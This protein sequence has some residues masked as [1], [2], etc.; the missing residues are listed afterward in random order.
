MNFKET[1]QKI[2]ENWAD[3]LP[4]LTPG[5][6]RTNVNGRP[7]YICPFCNHGAHGDGLAVKPGTTNIR[8]FACGFSGSII[9]LYMKQEDIGFKEAVLALAD[10]LGL[11]IENGMNANKHNQPFVSH[12]SVFRKGHPQELST[13]HKESQTT[14]DTASQIDLKAYY[15]VCSS[16]L[17]ND[18]EA[19][20]YLQGRG[21]SLDN[22]L[23]HGFGYDPEADP[24]GRGY[25]TKRII[26]PTS[27]THYV[28]RAIDPSLDRRSKMNNKGGKPGLFNSDVL[29][30]S[31]DA[32]F[33]VEGII[34][35]VSIMEC[36]DTSAIALNGTGNINL[37]IE[38]VKKQAPVA[39]LVIC[40]DN[41]E[42]GKK[43]TEQLRSELQ[44]FNI[45]FKVANIFGKQK[46]ANEALLKNRKRFFEEIQRAKM[47][48]AARPDNV[49]DHSITFM[50]D[51]I[52]KYKKQINT[53]YKGLDKI[54]GGLFAGL[55]VVA[56]ITSI[57][58]TAFVHQMAD[59]IAAS[60]QDI[61]FFSLEHSRLELVSKSIARQIAKDNYAEDKCKLPTG[62]SIRREHLPALV[63]KAAGT[64]IDLVKDKLSV[65]ESNFNCNISFIGDYIRNFIRRTN[66]SPVIIIDYLQLLQP[67]TINNRIQTTREAVEY[68]MTELKRISRELSVPIISISSVNQSNNLTPIAVESL[69]ESGG[70]EDTADVVWGLQLQCLNNAIF[71]QANK[72][73]EEREIV[74]EAKAATPRKIELVCLKNR[75]GISGFTQSYYYY[76]AIDLFVECEEEEPMSQ[77]NFK[78]DR[79]KKVQSR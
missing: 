23:I 72:M 50:G 34:D 32:V 28:A 78:S 65:I 31:K 21:I 17:A 37:L 70:I 18:Q 52:L 19:I 27:S 14:A 76:P 38:Q 36:P 2:K 22:A 12:I 41:D 45:N 30:V 75:Y 66:S 57:C 51:D 60:G 77:Q 33:V 29:Y 11:H 56:A 62:L 16:N 3:L 49:S 44:R 43:A 48:T 63:Q 8:C 74:R 10:M 64:Y 39:T 54:T 40:M 6:A 13:L 25:K 20:D 73:K 26:M 42:A 47:Q 5:R 9:D 4:E 55:Y 67:L 15:V 35:A 71:D 46:D 59:Q 58:R 1:I 79:R 69:K 68:T 61:L 53:G 24:S 7:S